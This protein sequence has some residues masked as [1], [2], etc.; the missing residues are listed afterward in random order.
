MYSPVEVDNRKFRLQPAYEA[1]VSSSNHFIYFKHEH[2]RL[3]HFYLY[4][5]SIFRAEAA[6]AQP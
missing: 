5:L 3:F 6:A 1:R 4:T 2:I